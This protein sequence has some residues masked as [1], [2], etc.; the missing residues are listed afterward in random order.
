MN[1]LSLKSYME[2]SEDSFFDRKSSK[3]K[4]QDLVRHI[5][6]F[7]NAAGGQLAIGIEDNGKLAGYNSD[8]D[9]KGELI[10]VIFASTS[11]TPRFEIEKIEYV[12]ADGTEKYILI[13]DIQASH[14]SVIFTINKKDCYL[15]MGDS[16]IAITYEQI[17]QLEFDKGARMFEDQIVV[18]S[19]LKDVDESLVLKYKQQINAESLSTEQVLE[20]RGFLIDGHLT[21]GGILLFGNNTFKFLPNSRIRFIRYDG[22]KSNTGQRLNIIKEYD[23]EDAIPVLIEKI[24]KDIKSQLRD[25]TYLQDDGKFKNIPEYP[26]FAWFEGVVNALTHRDY[27]H[28]GDH[29]RVIM[30]DDR[31]E[32]ISPGKLPNIVTLENMKT[33]RYSRNPRIARVLTEFG[34]V[35]ELNEGV[36]RIY[37]EMESFDLGAPEYSEPDKQFLLLRLKNNI[38]VRRNR[39]QVLNYSKK[40]EA[41]EL[42][43]LEIEILSLL[44]NKDKITTKEVAHSLEKSTSYCS[45][46]LK[47]MTDKGLLVWNGSAKSDPH[48]YYTLKEKDEQYNLLQNSS[49]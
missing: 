19:S 14:D 11:P 2:K 17:M 6:G 16:T 35:R 9:K 39:E 20:A 44:V 7:A 18:A 41:G 31:L 3:V 10:N 29:V 23:Y 46:L 1:I 36:K 8:V 13:V 45:K 30:Y 32:V 48:Q 12:E 25:F 24:T 4:F 34:W 5:I 47:K 49:K 28:R 33:T 43:S 38:F 21:N 40:A 37:E 15:R 27:S 26:E 42:S 22:S